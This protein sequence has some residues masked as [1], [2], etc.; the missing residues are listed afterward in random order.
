MKAGNSRPARVVLQGP[1]S[2]QTQSD[3]RGAYRFDPIPPGKYRLQ[4]SAPGL[5]V[6]VRAGGIDSAPGIGDD[7][8]DKPVTVTADDPAPTGG[9]A[10]STTIQKKND[11]GS[12]AQ[13]ERAI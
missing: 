11:G 3:A 6:E 8:G 2:K 5:R 10:Q 4:A 1:V 9:S 13:S 7:R 12:L